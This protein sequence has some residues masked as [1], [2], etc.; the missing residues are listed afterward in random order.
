MIRKVTEVYELK[1]NKPL[2]YILI[3]IDYSLA[4][5]HAIIETLNKAIIISNNNCIILLIIIALLY[6]YIAL[7]SIK[8]SIKIVE[9]RGISDQKATNP[10][11]IEDFFFERKKK[12]CWEPIFHLFFGFFE[13]NLKTIKIYRNSNI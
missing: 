10:S 13:I 4:A 5:M 9:F 2:A 7:K 3:S 8:K 12:K 6:K 11:M 1:Y